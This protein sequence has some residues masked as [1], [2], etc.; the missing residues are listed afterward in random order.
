MSFSVLFGEDVDRE[1]L[2]KLDYVD[3]ACYEPKYQG[4][5]DKTVVRW[6]K[7]PRQFV[8]VMDDATGN[9]AGYINFFPCEEGLYQDNLSRCPIIRD[10]D[11]TPEE[12]APWRKDANHVF[13]LSLAVH[14]HYQGGQVIRLLSD[15]WIAYMNRL[16]GQGYPIT[17]I[18]G[19]A[20]SGHGRH[21][22]QNYLF[23]QLRHLTDGN[24]VY[25][26]D[27]TRLDN[28][29]AHKLYFKTYKN[30]VYLL[31]PLVEHEANLRV[32]N[33]L[34][35]AEAGT[36]KPVGASPEECE[37]TARLMDD[38][39]EMIAYECSNEVVQDLSL[40][41][42]GSFDFL[43]TT[44]DYEGLEEGA[45]EVVIGCARGH[46]VLAAH[47]KTHMCV[48][49]VVLPGYPFSVTQLED[50]VSYGYVKV[51]DPRLP[52]GWGVAANAASD[53]VAPAGAVAAVASA[54]A[55]SGAASA[56][57]TAGDAAAVTAAAASGA[58]S[59]GAAP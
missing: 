17:D 55:A 3:E 31:M 14:P 5:L 7:N 36:W 2:E 48:L 54:G 53:G 58:A 12:V 43:H 9:M 16:E 30:D 51:R 18:M 46:A 27:G 29:L 39:Q 6:E 23:R 22:L 42:L 4:E 59:A 10:D 49:T 35:D 33:L 13:V 40:V 1:F 24:T 50:Q 34:A 57:A 47:P 25:I 45:D 28:L 20:V 32:A 52:S 41:H 56:G 38:L 26:C 11:I 44:D 37:I 8:F 21:A 19:T 15:N